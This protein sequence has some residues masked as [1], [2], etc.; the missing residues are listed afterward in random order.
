MGTGRFQPVVVK[1]S[2]DFKVGG[3]A[4]VHNRGKAKEET[5]VGKFKTKAAAAAWALHNH[6]LKLNTQFAMQTLNNQ[7]LELSGGKAR[8]AIKGGEIVADAIPVEDQVTEQA[9]SLS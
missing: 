9:E 1:E 3:V 8:E 5:I 7:C 4:I 2:Q 6:G